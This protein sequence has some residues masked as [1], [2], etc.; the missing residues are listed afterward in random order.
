MHTILS[1]PHYKTTVHTICVL[2]KQI[3]VPTIM[4]HHLDWNIIQNASFIDFQKSVQLY[5]LIM[6][7]ETI[8]SEIPLMYFNEH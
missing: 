8:Q 4:S 1:F 6:Q 3:V 5:F 2:Q 7:V